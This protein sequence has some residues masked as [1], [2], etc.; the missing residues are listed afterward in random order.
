MA[1]SGTE[2]ELPSRRRQVAPPA[3]FG[4]LRQIRSLSR[5]G[6]EPAIRIKGE[7][8]TTCNMRSNPFAP[9]RLGRTGKHLIELVSISRSFAGFVRWK[10]RSVDASISDRDA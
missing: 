9:A 4:V 3:H 5:E 1:V 2:R 8:V 10:M 7:G 6:G